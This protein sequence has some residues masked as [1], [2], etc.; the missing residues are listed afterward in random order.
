MVSRRML[1]LEGQPCEN[2]IR[3]IEK[4][5]RKEGKGRE[6]IIKEQTQENFP[7]LGGRNCSD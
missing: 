5:R 7:K 4:R 2:K 1:R 3:F 6:E